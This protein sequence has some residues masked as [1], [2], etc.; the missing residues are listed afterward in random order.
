VKS[1]KAEWYSNR[2]SDGHLVY[3][4]ESGKTLALV[5]DTSNENGEDTGKGNAD[6]IVAAVNA[7]A[8]VNADNPIAVAESIKEMYDALKWLQAALTEYRLRDVKKRYSL[9]VADS[10]ASK[11][12]AKAEEKV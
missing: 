7:C 6:L 2:F 3:Q 12:L 11:A 9:C 4:V 8:E 10:A 1:T 5:Y